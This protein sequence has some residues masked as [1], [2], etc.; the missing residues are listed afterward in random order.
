MKEETLQ[1]DIVKWCIANIKDD[2][3][4]FA[5]LNESESKAQYRKKLKLM[6]MLSGVPDLTFISESSSLCGL[7]NITFI[8]LKRPTTY[9]IG[10]KGKKVIDQRGGVQSDTQKDFEIRSEPF[11]RYF[12]V[13]NKKDFMEIMG[14]YDLTK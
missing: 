5:T 14:N 4:W 13:D 9:K 10:K 2:V 7:A 12:I 8:E 1:M 11:S 3:L 6:G